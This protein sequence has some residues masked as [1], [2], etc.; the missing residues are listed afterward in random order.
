[1]RT[2]IHRGALGPCRELVLERGEVEPRAFA[3]DAALGEV[4]DVQDPGVHVAAAAVKAEWPP[5]RDRV[6]ERLVGEMV[7]AV[8]P[9]HGVEAGDLQLGEQFSIE[10]AD[11]LCAAQRR[12]GS[13]GDVV[14]GIGSERVGDGVEIGCDL[15]SEVRVDELIHARA[16]DDAAVVFRASLACAATAVDE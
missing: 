8:P 10:G 6:Q 12:P 2:F 11:L 3:M 15:G 5:A 13:T 4:E 7:L 9:A 16:A 1:M 14:L